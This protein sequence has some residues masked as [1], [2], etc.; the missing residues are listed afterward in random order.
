MKTSTTLPRV[1]VVAGRLDVIVMRTRGKRVL[2]LGC[3]DAGLIEDRF[4]RGELMHQRLAAVTSDLW[5]VDVDA[6]GVEFLR[7]HGFPQVVVGDVTALDRITELAGRPFD[8]IVASE[9]LEHLDNPGLF[10]QAVRRFMSGSHTELVVTV[11][12]AFRVDTLLALLRGV[13]FVHPDH[14][15]WFSYHTITNLLRR[16]GFDIAECYVYTFSPPGI[17]RRRGPQDASRSD[18]R[19][20]VKQQARRL[21]GGA[22]RMLRALPRRLALGLLYRTTPFWGDGIIVVARVAPDAH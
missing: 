1:P 14:V 8:A 12:N 7:R 22:W 2:H 15:Y 9:I 5:G 10:L 20:P 17:L 6:A 18:G 11:P 19:L 16:H 4:R 13:E 21:I 3:V